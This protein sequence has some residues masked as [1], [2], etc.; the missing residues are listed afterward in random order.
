MSEHI[1]FNKRDIDEINS[2][3]PN[4]CAIILETGYQFNRPINVEVEKVSEDIDITI[5][6]TILQEAELPNRNG[7]IYTK[8]AIDE[9]LNR[10]MI[11]EKIA[12]K[13]WFG[14]NCHPVEQTV[15][16]QTRIDPRNVSHI[17]TDFWWEDNLLYGKIETANTNA[18]R[19]FQGLIRQG[20]EASFSMRGLGGESS[21]KNGYEFIDKGLFIMCYD[22]VDFPSH[23]KAYQDKILKEDGDESLLNESHILNEGTMISIPVSS[24]EL[25]SILNES[26]INNKYLTTNDRDIVDRFILS[27]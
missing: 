18:G 9:A 14:E 1:M 25:E 26:N 3:N 5:F 24:K 22:S 17:V 11:Q 27:L 7:R 2:V 19:D 23:E 4:G 12:H 15:K 16:R 6:T 21:Q 13:K 8:K 10:K 20:C